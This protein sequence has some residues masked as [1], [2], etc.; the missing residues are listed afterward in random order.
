MFLRLSTALKGSSLAME[1]L[2]CLLCNALLQDKRGITA[3]PL[4]RI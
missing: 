2:S 1:V 4:L 3:L